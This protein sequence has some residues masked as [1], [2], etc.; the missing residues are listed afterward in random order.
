M[1]DALKE[2]G[3]DPIPAANLTEEEINLLTRLE[4]N[5]VLIEKAKPKAK[6]VVAAKKP[7]PA[8]AKSKPIL[9]GKG[10]K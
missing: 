6:P 5:E 4:L 3:L 2:S 1:V 9:K 10:K 7:A 8:P